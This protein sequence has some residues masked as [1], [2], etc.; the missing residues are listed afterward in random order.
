MQFCNSAVVHCCTGLPP[1]F[2]SAPYEKRNDLALVA[3]EK[4]PL[5]GYI[6]AQGD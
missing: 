6:A 1:S 2:E 4:Q 5:L 3:I